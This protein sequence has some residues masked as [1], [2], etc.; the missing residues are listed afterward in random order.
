MRPNRYSLPRP[1]VAEF[2]LPGHPDE[3]CDGRA[4]RRAICP[5][6]IVRRGSICCSTVRRPTASS[7]RPSSERSRRRGC[8]PRS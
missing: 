5:A 3:L 2:V 8:T 4:S 1:A 7:C 6:A